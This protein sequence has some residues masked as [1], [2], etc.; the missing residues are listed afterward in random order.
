M[1]ALEKSDVCVVATRVPRVVSAERLDV[2]DVAA[3]KEAL[4]VRARR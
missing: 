1:S 2:V 4:P 3:G